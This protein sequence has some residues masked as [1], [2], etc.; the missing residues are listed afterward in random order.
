MLCLSIT[1]LHTSSDI[2]LKRSCVRPS[3]SPY[4]RQAFPAA[5]ISAAVRGSR[6]WVVGAGT[7]PTCG[8][9]KAGRLTSP[10]KLSTKLAFP[11]AAGAI[12]L[13]ITVGGLRLNQVV[14]LDPEE[15]ERRAP[16]SLSREFG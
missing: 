8:G 12:V 16:A 11:V 5:D 14:K 6:G 1:S 10:S 9:V 3:D 13:T 15:K 2:E 4:N 7:A